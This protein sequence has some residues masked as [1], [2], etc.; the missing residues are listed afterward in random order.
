M[1][2]IN[3]E[4]KEILETLEKNMKNKDDLELV[5]VQMFNLYNLFFDEVTN[6]ETL[7]NSRMAEMA[8]KQKDVDE[9]LGKIEK[10]IKN[11]SVDIYG[12][13]ENEDEEDYNFTIECPYCNFEFNVE[14]D[15]LENTITCPECKK[16]IEI[17]LGTRLGRRRMRRM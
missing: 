12:E 4:F 13:E 8:G 6:L 15:E 1:S 3:A 16:D 7:A 17:R 2:N 11:I 9:R 14:V 10:E 5:K